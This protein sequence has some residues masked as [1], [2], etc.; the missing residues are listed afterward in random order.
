VPDAQDLN[1]VTWKQ[2]VGYDVSRQLRNDKLAGAVFDA[3]F[4]ALREALK[5]LD[6]IVNDAAYRLAAMTARKPMP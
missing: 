5:G 3:G 6:G 2:A 1:G 4:A